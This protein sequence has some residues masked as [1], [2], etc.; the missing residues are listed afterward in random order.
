VELGP[1]VQISVGDPF[2]GCTADDGQEADG[3]VKFLSGEVEPYIEANPHVPG[4]LI[5]VWQQDR[6]SDGGSRGLYSAYSING[7][8]TWTPIEIPGLTLCN[9]DPGPYERATD[10]WV[11][12]APDGA[13]Y[14]IGLPFDSDPAIFGGNHA[15]TVNKSTDGGATWSAPVALLAENDPNV[16]NDKE[17]ITADSTSANRVYATWD[18]LELF[19]ASAQQAAALAVAVRHEH[20]KVIMGGRTLQQMRTAALAAAAEPPEFKGPTL[21]TRTKDAGASWEMPRIVYDPGADNQTINNIVVVRPNGELAL[22]F[23]EILGQ[24]NGTLRVNISLKRSVDNGFSFIPTNGVIR[25]QRIHSLAVDN[26]VGTFTPDERLPVRDAGILFDPAVDPNNGNLYLVWQDNRFGN[27]AVDQVAFSMS[28]NGGKTWSQ[29]IEINQTPKVKANRL[30]EAAFLPTI[31]VTADGLLAA[32]YYDFR[33]DDDIDELADQFV[34]FCDPAAGNCA[35]AKNW[36]REQRLTEDSFDI[37]DAP[38]TGAG[39][40]LGDYVGLAAAGGTLHPAYGIADGP[41]QSSI[42]TRKITVAPAVA[43]AAQ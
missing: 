36:G 5:A 25:A 43:S 21:F 34:A 22:L 12:F 30:R 10:P 19:S 39:D 9:A 27:G 29:P 40:F 41:E 31:A 2:D 4:N 33:N 28:K 7:G 32:T 6:W 1:Q 15:V 20:D 42:Y 14:V 38:T 13:A 35:K 11:T 24:P 3:S 8:D 23:T 26:P 17:S 37:R 16:F 18:R